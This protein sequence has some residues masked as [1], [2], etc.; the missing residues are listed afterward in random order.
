MPTLTRQ[1]THVCEIDRASSDQANA[2]SCDVGKYAATTN[3]CFFNFESLNTQ[4]PAGSTIN[5]ASLVLAQVLGGHATTLTSKVSLRKGNWGTFTWSVGPH[6]ARDGNQFMLT[7]ANAATRTIDVT[8][9]VQWIVDNNSPDHIFRLERVPNDQSGTNDAKRFSTTPANHSIQINYTPLAPCGPPTNVTI[10]PSVAETEATLTWSGATGG[11][12]NAITGYEIA[13][14]D[15][16]DG[17]NWGLWQPPAIVPSSSGSGSYTVA[18]P[19]TRGHY[20][21]FRIRTRG[22]L[23]EAYYSGWV[24]SGTLRKNVLPSPPGVFTAAPEVYEGGS[25]TLSW[26]GVVPGTSAIKSYTIQSASSMDGGVTWSGFAQ[27]ATILSSATSGSTVVAADMRDGVKVV[28]RI[29]TVDSFDAASAYASSNIVSMVTAP[30]A[31]AV[32][33]PIFGKTAYSIMPRALLKTGAYAGGSQTLRIRVDGGPWYDSAADPARF[34]V[35]GSLG[36]NTATI[37]VPPPLSP[38]SHTLSV[39]AVNAATGTESTVVTIS[40][41][42][43]ASPFSALTANVTTV[44]AAHIQQLRDAANAV[45]RYYGLPIQVWKETVAAGKTPVWRWPLHI[46]EIRSAVDDIV[47]VINAHD[48]SGAFNVLPVGWL[49]FTAGRPRADLM[50]QLQDLILTL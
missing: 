42:I 30:P 49:P 29:R 43:A 27:L 48:A 15:S 46:A 7:G 32:L 50:R 47:S 37:F 31:P 20:R 34:S 6:L 38:G 33:A 40:F 1:C 17:E 4:I 5:S 26:S 18:P 16:P 8:N 13:Y 41:I 9:I 22:A 11:G 10:S 45:R 14:S 3:N 28:Y 24:T 12:A 25:I 35:P 44:R 21:R 23:G 39:K 2:N 36:G 19:T